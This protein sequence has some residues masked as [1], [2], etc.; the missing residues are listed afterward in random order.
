MS[1]D[2]TR[3]QGYLETKCEYMY[4]S[5]DVEILQNAWKVLHNFLREI[6]AGQLRL[7]VNDTNTHIHTTIKNQNQ[8]YR[9]SRCT[10]HAKSVHFTGVDR[11]MCPTCVPPKFHLIDNHHR[12]IPLLH[13]YAPTV[14]EQYYSAGISSELCL[15]PWNININLSAHTFRVA[16]RPQMTESIARRFQDF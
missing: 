8:T 16:P 6:Q 12:I 13:L 5:K 9:W 2:T 10:W 4:K 1:F 11:I 14:I 3:S 15:V 7:S